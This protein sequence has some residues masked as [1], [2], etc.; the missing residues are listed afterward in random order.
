[1]NK[2][3]NY[4]FAVAISVVFLVFWLVW[5]EEASNNPGTTDQDQTV[6]IIITAYDYELVN[7]SIQVAEDTSLL[8]LMQQNYDTVVDDDGFIES[9]EGIEQSSADG[10]YWIYEVNSEAVF[11]SAEDFIPKDEDVISWELTSF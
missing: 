5:T 9:I 10:L 6:H 7:D 11:E 1:M 2:K 8:D 4:L 3:V